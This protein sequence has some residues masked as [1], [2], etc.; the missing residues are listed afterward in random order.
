MLA[1]NMAHNNA[2][3]QAIL[4]SDVDVAILQEAPILPD[5]L[6][7][8]FVVSDDDRFFSND[9]PWRALIA[10]IAKS[11]KL[12]YIPIK[13]Q[14]L[15]GNN[16]EALMVSRFG[17]IDAFLLRIRE[18]KEEYIVV[19]LYANWMNSI[20]AANSSWI[21]AD[22]SAH[23]LISDLSALIGQ[24]QGHKIIVAGDLNLLYGYGEGRSRYWGRR[25][26]TIFDRMDALGF[27]FIGPQAPGGGKQADPWPKELPIDSLNVPTFR[28]YKNKP[29]TATRQLDFV[30]A[31]ESIANRV[32]VRALNSLEEW[33]PSDHCRIMIE[34]GV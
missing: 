18:T 29:E 2:N 8:S 32:K 20:K 6:R 33:G 19:S 24:Q 26:A 14:P 15:G 23:R 22:A 13:T 28:T 3:W 16:P 7:D 17:S 4:D 31:S 25:Y 9:L 11:D 5:H 12:D 10:G 27:K 21:F 1:W 34:L 30:F